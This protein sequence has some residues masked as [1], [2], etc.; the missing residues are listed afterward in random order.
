MTACVL[1]AA[2]L[3]ASGCA[4]VP[5]MSDRDRGAI[6]ARYD[7]KTMYLKSSMYYGQFFGDRYSYLVSPR[8]FADF[9][10]L[11]GADGDPIS[12][13]EVLGIIPAGRA[14]TVQRVEF[15]P[16][17]RP[18]FT[19]RFFPWVY[20][21]VDGTFTEKPHILV[22]APNTVSKPGFEELLGMYLTDKNIRLE[23]E[24]RPAAIRKAIDEKL[25][26]DGM[27]EQDL[28]MSMGSPDAVNFTDV[29]GLTTATWSYPHRCVKLS[30]GVV[31]KTFD[32]AC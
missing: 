27:T 8:S 23:V 17:G 6:A 1:A 26:L 25:I 28:L 2:A 11:L 18:L 30:G 9:K 16:A 4:S 22:I 32:K 14:V 21:K 12:P 24:S 7:G 5:V 15:P 10:L 3:L 13:G 29:N 19:P 31:I 20:M